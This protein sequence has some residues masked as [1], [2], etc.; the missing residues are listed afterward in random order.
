MDDWGKKVLFTDESKFS[1]SYRRV[2]ERRRIKSGGVSLDYCTEL[3]PPWPRRNCA[4]TLRDILVCNFVEEDSNCSAAQSF[5]GTTWRPKETDGS[6]LLCAALRH[7]LNSAQSPEI[8]QRACVRV[9]VCQVP[10]RVYS[11]LEN[12]PGNVRVNPCE[13][14]A[15]KC[16]KN[17]ER[18][19]VLSQF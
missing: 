15:G 7:E 17:S 1:I 3:I 10:Q 6:I 11:P 19:N 18:A 9:C 4:P 14:R 16:P 8:I 13:N 2:Y 5:T 12:Y